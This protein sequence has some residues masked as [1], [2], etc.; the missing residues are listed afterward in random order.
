[1]QARG[2]LSRIESRERTEGSWGLEEKRMRIEGK[3]E[4]GRNEELESEEQMKG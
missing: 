1:M 2:R 3:S 4:V